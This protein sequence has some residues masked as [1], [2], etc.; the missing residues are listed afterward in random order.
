MDELTQLVLDYKK[1]PTETNFKKIYQSYRV[2]KLYWQVIKNYGVTRFPYIVQ[3]DIA[4]G[5]H[6]EMLFKCVSIF[7]QTKNTAFSTLFTWWCMSYVR[8]KKTQWLRRK[9]LMNAYSLD[10]E[11][12]VKRGYSLF[13][14]NTKYRL[15]RN[16]AENNLKEEK[17]E[18]VPIR[19]T[20]YPKEGVFNFIIALMKKKPYTIEE[21]MELSNATFNTIKQRI[22]SSKRKGIEIISVCGN[23][24]EEMYRVIERNKF[25]EDK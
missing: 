15:S 25:D 19:N 5:C 23:K 24:G 9:N 4:A 18:P 2:P 20:K 14:N 22:Q 8:S 3:E 12:T 6:S 7:D 21:L 11:I 10:D 13:N 17:E 16:V 1:K